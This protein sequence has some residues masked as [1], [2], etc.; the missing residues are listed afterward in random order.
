MAARLHKA[1]RRLGNTGIQVVTCLMD[2]IIVAISIEMMAAG[3][4]ELFPGLLA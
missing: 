1:A 4:G 3:L 2:L